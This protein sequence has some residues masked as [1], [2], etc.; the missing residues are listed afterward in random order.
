MA[1]ENPRWGYTRIRGALA[2][3]GY[4]ISR[5]TIA[6]IL[7]EHGIEPAPERGKRTSWRT[8]LK[9]HWESF[10]A[11]DFFTVEVATLGGLVTYY[12]V[13]VL[14]LSTR[15]VQIVG[16][17]PEPDTAFMVQIGRNLTSAP[18]VFL[19]G[20]RFLIMDRDR[21][22]SDEFRK[23]LN[24]FGM[25]IVR[26]P[27]RSPNLNAYS[28]RFVLSIKQECLDRMI[29]FFEKSLRRAISSYVAHYH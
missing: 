7:R 23:L 26:L 1:R 19:A 16:L 28:E 8:F 17:T 6:N 13:I 29:F 20:K 9:A 4:K 25:N 21:K 11:A 24:K 18:S 5:T 22:Y 10:A 12:V 3:L 15:R 14:E 27:P 2:N